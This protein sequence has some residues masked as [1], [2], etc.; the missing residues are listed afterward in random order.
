MNKNRRILTIPNLMTLAR[1]VLLGPILWCLARELRWWVLFWGSIGI[2]T[3]VLD[4][5]V[6]RRLNQ[7]SD[8][9]RLMD[10]VVDK[11]TVLTVTLYMSLSPYY[12]FP[13]WYFIF[14]LVREIALMLGGLA[15]VRKI[16]KIME[17]E[18]PGKW[19]AFVTGIMVILFILDLQP[20]A[21]IM[22][23][24]SLALTVFST[25]HYGRRFIRAMR[26]SVPV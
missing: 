21:W 1:L 2:V 13:L 4:G 22:L 25:F 5:W 15:M 3:D 10:P 14:E 7:R 18:R 9:G 24:I 12:S 16:H 20:A 19:S 17:S 8:L 6:A 26:Q 23:W 11:V